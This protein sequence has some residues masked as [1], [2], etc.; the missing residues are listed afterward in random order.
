[1]IAPESSRPTVASAGGSAEPVES[2]DQPVTTLRGAQVDVDM[3]R[4]GRVVVLGCLVALVAAAAILIVAGI[5]SNS[6]ITALR[7]HGVPVSATVTGCTGLMGGTGAQ[8]AGYS[9]TATYTLDGTQHRQAV[10]GLAFHARGDT[11]AGVAVPGDPKL[12]ST[13]A[14]IAAQHASWRVFVVPGVLLAV[15]F[16]VGGLSLRRRWFPRTRGGSV[17]VGP[18]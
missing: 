16:V 12:F 13:P 1:M 15:A 14:H 9:C 5:H 3:R 6:Q 8:S 2:G 11:L 10:P 4:A 7:Q 18:R 17:A